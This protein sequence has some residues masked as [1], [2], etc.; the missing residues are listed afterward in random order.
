MDEMGILPNFKGLLCHDHWK[1]YY[2]YDCTHCLCNAHHL[3]ELQRAWEMDKQDGASKMK[4]LLLE[5][6]QAVI[7]AKGQLTPKEVK[8]YRM[9]YRKILKVAEIECPPP[10]ES[11]RKK[12][13]RGRLKRSKSRNLL[14]RLKSFEDDVLRF[15]EI[16][17]VEFTNNQGERDIRM[18]K[19]QQK[20]SGCFRSMKGAEIHAR[21]KS[22]LSTCLKNDVGSREALEL[23]FKGELPDF[24]IQ[25]GEKLIGLN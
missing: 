6:S 23:P 3:R 20:I 11:L 12:G 16:E 5:A 25:A 24:V 1:P 14:E 15:M 18:M 10:D 21:I 8:K 19:V 17:I 9:R 22:Y 4:Q 7:Q 13:Q 2:N